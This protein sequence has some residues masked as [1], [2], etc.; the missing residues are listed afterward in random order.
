MI[1]VGWEKFYQDRID[2]CS[3]DVE[4]GLYVLEEFLH[5]RKASTI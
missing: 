4:A 1:W 2:N 3:Q 5:Q